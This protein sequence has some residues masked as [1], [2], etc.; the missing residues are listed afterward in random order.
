MVYIVT[1]L[2]NCYKI[3]N[4]RQF[5]HQRFKIRYYFYK[6]FTFLK[7]ILYLVFFL[8]NVWLFFLEK[9]LFIDIRC[10]EFN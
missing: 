1:F 5:I 7:N 4:D 2:T 6:S 9:E 3:S 8:M 10:K